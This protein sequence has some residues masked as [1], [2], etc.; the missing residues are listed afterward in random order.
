M[1]CAMQVV[2]FLPL[3]G[4]RGKGSMCCG[5]SNLGMDATTENKKIPA[6]TGQ[7]LVPHRDVR[8]Q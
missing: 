1:P 5:M 7:Y 3:T 2:L 6:E 4:E 8:I